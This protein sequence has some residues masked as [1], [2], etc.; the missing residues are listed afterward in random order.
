MII[1]YNGHF[2]DVMLVANDLG[3]VKRFKINESPNNTGMEPVKWF[4]ADGPAL[5]YNGGML[6]YGDGRLFAE[7]PELPQPTWGERMGWFHCIAADVCGDTRE[8][9]VLYNP[10]DRF[11]RIYTPAPFRED[12]FDSYKAGPG[13]YNPRL[14]D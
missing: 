6:W 10:W 5:L 12:A 3:I 9:L 1:R 7:I 8:E 4:G 11:I 2:P 13:Q 14:M